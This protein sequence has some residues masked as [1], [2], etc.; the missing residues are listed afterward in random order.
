MP[1]T[2][3]GEKAVKLIARCTLA[4]AWA[5]AACL[6]AP[7][8]EAY[9]S[10]N[11]TVVVP[12]TGGTTMDILARLFAEG[13]SKRFGRG[14]VVTNRPGAG[15]L[16]AAQA[17]ASG[18]SDGYTLLFTNSAH[19]ILGTM[20]K[21]LPFDPVAD[22]VG[23]CMVGQ[24]PAVVTV[25]HAL[26]VHTLR[27][28]VALAKSKPGAL[29]YGSAGVGTAT[30]L[31]GAYFAFLTGTEL[32]H[33]PYTVSSTIITDILGGRIHVTFAP[34]AF[35]LPLLQ[36]GQ[37]LGLAVAD[38]QP[39]REPI[40]VPTA[41]AQGVDYSN[42]TWYGFLA[43]ARTPPAV[44]KT[45]HDAIVAVGNEPEIQTKIRVQ[46]I[47]PRNVGLGDFD[48]LIRADMARLA[49]L[50]ATIGRSN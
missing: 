24:A 27:E 38:N 21:N 6:P 5:V 48:G 10:R 35:T 31:A 43:P 22:F 47:T 28:F 36:N 3:A 29:N 26:G 34:A 46:G 23:V 11:V 16:I 17:V 7:A 2:A 41:L 30:H 25:S 15:G 8:Q 50:L 20:N 13:L 44:L 32:V 49:P 19:T 39:I 42:A 40:K 33:V 1:R 12:L 14:F 18:P 45:L 9:P 4:L 37:L